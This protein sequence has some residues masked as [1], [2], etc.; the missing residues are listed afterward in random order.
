MV[1]AQILHDECPRDAI[2]L[3]II[4][5]LL[6]PE[7]QLRQASALLAFNM[8]W[9]CTQIRSFIELE[10]TEYDEHWTCEIT[11]AL[12]TAIENESL[13]DK[14]N[15]ETAFRL[16]SAA[17]LLLAFSSAPTVELA[18]LVGLES[19]LQTISAVKRTQH[20][21]LTPKICKEIKSIL[22]QT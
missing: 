20:A 2:T 15:D 16:V 14:K 4:D 18:Q 5:T 8:A 21:E 13:S 3:L 17:G 1:S 11:A 7:Y 6:A 22:L 10:C 9:T 19:Y 12:C